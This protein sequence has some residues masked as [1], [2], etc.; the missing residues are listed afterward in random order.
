[1]RREKGPLAKFK[2][3]EGQQICPKQLAI[4]MIQ[5][6]SFCVLDMGLR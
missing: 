2:A 6:A 3:C 1:M 5:A 4:L